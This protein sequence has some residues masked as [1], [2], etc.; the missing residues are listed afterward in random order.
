MP[1]YVDLESG[2]C[3]FQRRRRQLAGWITIFCCLCKE[4]SRQ[5]RF[6]LFF[7]FFFRERKRSRYVGWCARNKSSR[8]G[9]VWARFN[10][11]NTYVYRMYRNLSTVDREHSKRIWFS[12]E[13]W[14]TDDWITSS[15]SSLLVLSQNCLRINTLFSCSD[16]IN[17]NH[18]N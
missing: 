12:N 17:E 3:E 1:D 14:V 6:I 2:F 5:A 15:P 7:F 10:V 4:G 18:G 8:L 16:Y 9:N 11:Q 13:H